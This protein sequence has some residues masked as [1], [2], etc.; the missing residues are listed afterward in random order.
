MAGRTAPASLP[1]FSLTPDDESLLGCSPPLSI[2]SAA[3][4][5]RLLTHMAR[6]RCGACAGARPAAANAT[7]PTSPTGCAASSERECVTVSQSNTGDRAG[8]DPVFEVTVWYACRC[9]VPAVRL[10]SEGFASSVPVD[11][12]LFRR[13]GRDYLV[14]DGRRIELGADARFRYAW[15]RAF[16]MTAAAV[17]D[18]CS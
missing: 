17:R 3:W 14:A 1:S 6:R 12:R 16:R 5:W 18:D 4:R 7:T 11:P 15:D 9:A 2:L 10:R 13:A 8:Y